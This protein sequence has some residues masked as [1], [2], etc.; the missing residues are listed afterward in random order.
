[1][2]IGISPRE[3]YC[4][5]VRLFLAFVLLAS[6][7]VS[8]AFG[9]STNTAPTNC[10]PS[11][12]I[13]ETNSTAEREYENLLDADDAAQ[14]EA[15][16]WIQENNDFRANG[17]GVTDADL[18]RRIRDRFEP[19]RKA[20]EDFVRRCPNHVRARIAY[21][22]LL[23]DL[24]DE[25]GAQ[26]QWEKALELDPKNPAVYNN[27][28]GTY[29]ESGSAQKAFDYF[30]KAIDLNPAEGLYYHNFGNS[31]FVLRKQAMEYYHLTEQQV[32]AKTLL[33]YSNA[34]RLAP[35]NFP[36]ASDL[37][38]TYYAIQPFP[39]DD[40]LECWTN[41]LKLAHD[42]LEREGVLVHFARI[43][44]LAGKF[45]EARAQLNC[46][47]NENYRVLKANLLRNIE[48][49]EHPAPATNSPAGASATNQLSTR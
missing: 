38:Q 31:L 46:V 15:D 18:N 30:S 47:S 24:Q 26:Q 43:K 4:S 34:V 25:A 29:S 8:W 48:L 28:A 42:D 40:S 45:V 5:A 41:A 10:P 11:S 2:R 32:F 44:M 13:G 9:A 7:V 49:R 20:Y 37:A 36:F 6:W 3:R 1:L 35:E 19:V 14:A 16:K 21:G 22:S 39:V 33:L 23:G 17:A 27:L 12:V